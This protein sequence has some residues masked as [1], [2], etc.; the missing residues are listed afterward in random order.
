MKTVAILSSSVR[1][2]RLSHRVALYLQNYLESQALAQ[3]EMLDLKAYNFPLFDERFAMQKQPSEALIEFTQRF[4]QADAI[5]IVSPVYN[6]SFPAA[7]KNVIDLYYKEWH[8]KVTGVV[9]VTY[10]GVPP[11]ATAQQLQ[12]LLLKLDA[13]VVPT[14]CTMIRTESNFSPEGRAAEPK[15]MEALAKP[16]L[17]ELFWLLK[18]TQA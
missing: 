10:G 11:I 2:G 18:K 6:A 7:L 16:M 17:D 12:A 14:F 1:E 9:T 8:H 4:K 15:E 5:I 13:L 3:V